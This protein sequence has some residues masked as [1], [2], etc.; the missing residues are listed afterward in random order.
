MY[1]LLAKVLADKGYRGAL[2]TLVGQAFEHRK[3]E[4]EISQR[5]VGAL[6]LSGRTETMDCRTYLDLG[7]KML[8]S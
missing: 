8:A 5:L 4:V 2:V 1:E 6:M 7:A 3:V